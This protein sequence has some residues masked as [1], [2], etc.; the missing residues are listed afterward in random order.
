EAPPP[1]GPLIRLP[2]RHRD[3]IVDRGDPKTMGHP[4]D[5]GKIPFD[6]GRPR[7]ESVVELEK[8]SSFRIPV[9]LPEP[10][11]SNPRSPTRSR[12]R[13]SAREF[14]EPIWQSI[15]RATT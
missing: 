7:C 6:D 4:S 1:M 13:S 15:L 9:G 10:S 2:R 8:A 12:A 11:T 14:T 3:D 5:S